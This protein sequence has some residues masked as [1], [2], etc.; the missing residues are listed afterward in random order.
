MVITLVRP[1]RVR[2]H[3]DVPPKIAIEIEVKTGYEYLTELGYIYKKNQKL[4]NFGFEK[5]IWIITSVGK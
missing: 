3:T 1:K 5:V 4:L 2:R